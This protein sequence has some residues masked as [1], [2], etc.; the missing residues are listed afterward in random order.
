MNCAKCVNP[1]C[2]VILNP[3]QECDEYKRLR[4]EAKGL[5]TPKEAKEIFS[6]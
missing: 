2:R 5:P 1:L 3:A 6:W 4:D